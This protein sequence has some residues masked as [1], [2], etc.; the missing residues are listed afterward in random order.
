MVILTPLR[1]EHQWTNAIKK[2][3]LRMYTWKKQQPQRHNADWHL[4]TLFCM[5]CTSCLTKA[6]GTRVSDR[7]SRPRTERRLF[8]PT[9][10][11]SISHHHSWDESGSITFT[12]L[13]STDY[14]G[15]KKAKEEGGKVKVFCLLQLEI[16]VSLSLRYTRSQRS[17]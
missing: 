15:A 12:Q 11:G 10:P 3:L 17:E 1:R 13:R 4:D 16:K 14:T 5:F 2:R 7:S 6:Q 8:D 9:I